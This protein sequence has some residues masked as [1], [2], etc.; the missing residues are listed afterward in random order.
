MIAMPSWVDHPPESSASV[1]IVG[2]SIPCKQ[3]E[4]ALEKAWNS[5]LIRIAMTEF[6]E[7][8]E[9]TSTSKETLKDSEFERKTV[10]NFQLINWKG[11]REMK[12]LGSPFVS[13]DPKTELYTVYRLI[14]WNKIDLKVSKLEADDD[15]EKLKLGRD[16]KTYK[17]PN[18]PEDTDKEELALS[19]QM[20]QIRKLNLQIKSR[21]EMISKVLSEL[22]CGTKVTDVIKILGQPDKI[23]YFDVIYGTYKLTHWQDNFVNSIKDKLGNGEERRLCK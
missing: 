10:Q 1:Y 3:K 13:F 22:K 6:P 19:D 21:D 23:D 20:D 9:L 14:S 12:S 8:I 17:L 2:E 16:V 15:L 7:L 11:L 5:A 18:T 4:D